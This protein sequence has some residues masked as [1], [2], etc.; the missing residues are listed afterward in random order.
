MKMR[1]MRHLFAAAFVY[2]T[3]M[4]ALS[5]PS[6]EAAVTII[7]RTGS[8]DI[9]SISPNVSIN[10]SGRVAF[11]GQTKV[12]RIAFTG[13][14]GSPKSLF[15]QNIDPRVGNSIRINSAGQVA[16]SR[17]PW[18]V[19]NP[20]IE[21]N[22]VFYLPPWTI[23]PAYAVGFEFLQVFAPNPDGLRI[24]V[25][26][27]GVL[28]Q[29]G[30]LTQ[31]GAF[32][33]IGPDFCID[34]IGRVAF[35]ASPELGV[36]LPV[37]FQLASAKP[38]GGYNTLYV[39]G[40]SQPMMAGD[41]TIVLRDSGPF[42]FYPGVTVLNYDLS[43]RATFATKFDGFDSVGRVPSITHDARYV[44][45][46][47]VAN[48][49]GAFYA[50]SNEGPGLF[51]VRADG[52]SQ[53]ARIVGLS[54]NPDG[55][56][57]E[58]IDEFQCVGV[59]SLDT[60]P[61]RLIVVFVAKD[62]KG[63]KGVYRCL[64]DTVSGKS[65]ELRLVLSIG[66]TVP[67]LG[68]VTDFNL[69]DPISTSG[70][71]AFWIRTETGEAVIRT[72]TVGVGPADLTSTI[73][74]LE[75]PLP[76]LPGSPLEIEV[77]IE[78]SGYSRATGQLTIQTFLAPGTEGVASE[79]LLDN[80]EVAI[81][82]EGGG[83]AVMQ[84]RVKLN[85]GT[86]FPLDRA[87]SRRIKAIINQ[88]HSISESNFS[89]NVS[90]SQQ[91]FFMGEIINV[92]T[93]GFNPRP[94]T[95]AVGGISWD[96]FLD[97]FFKLTNTLAHIPENDSILE[98]GIRSHLIRWG[99][100]IGFW[101]AFMNLAI[102]EIAMAYAVKHDDDPIQKA[103][104]EKAAN[105]LRELAKK[106]AQRSQREAAKAAYWAAAERLGGLLQ[107]SVE[108]SRRFQRI[109]LI[110]HSRG[111]AVNARLSMILKDAGYSIAEFVALDGYGKDWPGTSGTIGDLDIEREADARE[112]MNFQVEDSLG[113][114]IARATTFGG[115]EFGEFFWDVF[116][117]KTIPAIL[118]SSKNEYAEKFA[119]V[120]EFAAPTKEVRDY[121]AGLDMRSPVRWGP[122]N[123]RILSGGAEKSNHMNIVDVYR[124]YLESTGARGFIVRHRSDNRCLDWGVGEFDGTND[125]SG[126][127]SN[128]VFVA[129]PE[130]KESTEWR[131]FADGA[132]ESV[133]ELLRR[134]RRLPVEPSGDPV[135]DAWLQ[136]A[137][138]PKVLMESNWRVEGNAAIE[139]DGTNTFARLTQST[140]TSIGQVIE[141]AGGRKR[142]EF[143]LRANSFSEGDALE[144]LVEDDVVATIKFSNP[145]DFVRQVV[146][147]DS[148]FG[149]RF[150]KFQMVGRSQNTSKVS[151]DNLTVIYD[152]LP[153]LAVDLLDGHVILSWR[154]SGSG[155]TLQASDGL[156]AS[157][158]WQVVTNAPATGDGDS[159]VSLPLGGRSQFFRLFAP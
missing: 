131:A 46:Y 45:F 99:S 95:L 149:W 35:M 146:R 157:A 92:V 9:L 17:G 105:D 4:C 53:P 13:G 142:L 107:D 66:E 16:V 79:N 8:A 2:F 5:G 25:A 88:G 67:G 130:A 128:I 75:S 93:H 152:E 98:G 120:L 82:L 21:N 42:T 18:V 40:G 100:D 24:D 7:A 83:V 102:G 49:L 136:V 96:E 138:S 137:F 27:G 56:E 150:I 94:P 80:T 55:V 65:E 122:E 70:Q 51:V 119:E 106:H 33:H 124:R 31:N 145:G 47:G 158:M 43:T 135:V 115:G 54:G 61:N 109:N 44:T 121:L 19:Y 101:N 29:D 159:R 148:T 153:R 76:F 89:N 41:G 132:F 69:Y 62:T 74:I 133:G 30:F 147:L 57:F 78:N 139:I 91:C 116:V 32:G 15:R 111:A 144:V 155:V 73:T 34:D 3:V 117:A 97:P 84:R 129:H 10:R 50:K 63:G 60:I 6:A 14:G 114:M 71:I 36:Q 64:Y 87:G 108:T 151:L 68:R 37:S 90:R 125:G 141:F 134:G 81:D 143:D 52:S 48:A 104:L 39:N 77:T 28:A 85:A 1:S 38:S 23:S 11:V 156:G 140:N 110:G 126:V 20:A 22:E 86:D 58:N 113:Q 26:T 123:S 12:G 118:R 154:S 59:N 127:Q 112:F 72:P 103:I